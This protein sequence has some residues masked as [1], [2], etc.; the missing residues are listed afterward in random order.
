[1]RRLLQWIRRNLR[2]PGGC[3]G[4]SR[5]HSFRSATVS[6]KILSAFRQQTRSGSGRK[7]ILR[8][9]ERQNLHDS[10]RQTTNVQG[11][12]FYTKR[13]ERPAKLAHHGG[14]LPWNPHKCN[15][16]GNSRLCPPP[17]FSC[18]Q[19]VVNV[20]VSPSFSHSYIIDSDCWVT[21]E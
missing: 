4:N 9:L 15:S 5:L 8:F 10:S 16:I 20:Y 18:K 12:A 7:R 3:S 6:G 13:S 14:I 11:L 17:D 19:E 21:V 1:M 2:F